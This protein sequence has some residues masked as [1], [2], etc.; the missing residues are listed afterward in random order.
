[1]GQQQIDQQYYADRAMVERHMSNTASD[2]NI[3]LI[4]KQLA[5]RY[6]ALAADIGQ[7]RPKLTI[8][9]GGRTSPQQCLP[10]TDL[11]RNAKSGGLPLARRWP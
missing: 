9:V 6:E 10:E 5:D 8:A 1:M 4:H 11:R 7:P 3:A 2:P